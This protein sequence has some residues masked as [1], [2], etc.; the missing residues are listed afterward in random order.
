ME[1]IDLTQDS[2]TWRAIESVV[3]N[4]RVLYN[5][6]LNEDVFFFWGSTLFFGVSLEFLSNYLCVC[7]C[8]RAHALVRIDIISYRIEGWLLVK[9][10]E[11]GKRLLLSNAWCCVGIW[12]QGL[13]NVSRNFNHG[14][15]YGIIHFVHCAINHLCY[16]H[17]QLKF[18]HKLEPFFQ[19]STINPCAQGDV[20][21]NRY[22]KSIRQSHST[23]LQ[24]QN[25]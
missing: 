25:M 10:K 23:V 22:L 3:M 24:I 9:Q 12:L 2:N 15:C 8:V 6:W 21:T 13:R 4:L 11:H 14:I 16:Q 5:L 19:V 17:T 7:V 20:S 1:W 18:I